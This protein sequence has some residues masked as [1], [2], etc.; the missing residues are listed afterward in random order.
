[1]VQQVVSAFLA[2]LRTLGETLMRFSTPLAIAAGSAA[3]VAA[4]LWAADREGF[5]NRFAGFGDTSR[6]WVG[7]IG[8]ALLFSVLWLVLQDIE[9]IISQEQRTQLQVAYTTREDP[10]IA[11][12]YQYGPIAAY[13]EERTFT[14]TLT[15]PPSFVDR[16]GADGI[17][18]LSPY[19][20]DPS[21][22]NVLKLVDT[23]KRSGRD[24]VFTR[25]VT[26]LDETSIPIEKADVNVVLTFHAPASFQSA[27]FTSDLKAT[28]IFRNPLATQAKGRFRFA[29]PETGTLS[30][31]DLSVNGQSVG[32]PD[33]TGAYTWA[34]LL[35]PGQAA[36]AVVRY[37]TQ[38]GGVWRYD[39]GSGRRRIQAFRSRSTP[40]SLPD[41][42][43]GRS[44]LRAARAAR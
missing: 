33:K 1:M 41:S 19:L 38:G 9:P 20:Q 21:A 29:L 26:Q 13:V 40:T 6:R 44:I 2:N 42:C 43:A 23:F 15:L 18:V 28:Y 31:F 11:G 39:I 5:R 22:E 35:E 8:F 34:G 30:G 36:T 16:I 14:R 32:E 37:H 25:A 24:V 4:L 12:V 3:I 27:A 10:S 17:Q 7:W